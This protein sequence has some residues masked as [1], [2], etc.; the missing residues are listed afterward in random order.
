MY[1]V[2]QL[3]I[4]NQKDPFY[5]GKG[6]W[7][8][9]MYDHFEDAKRPRNKQ[10]NPLKCKVILSAHKLNQQVLCER[11]CEF[12]DE[13][14]ALNYEA[15]LISKYGRI[16]N[17]SGILTNIQ[18][19]GTQPP[20]QPTKTVFLFNNA[21]SLVKVLGSTFEA[22]DY[23]NVNVSVIQNCC[24]GRCKTCKGYILSYI[25]NKPSQEKIDK[26]FKRK[27]QL[28]NIFQYN[29][30]TLI[31]IHSSMREAAESIKS[32]SRKIS[33]AIREGC[34]HKGFYWK[35]N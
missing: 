24:A 33:R 22:A 14:T 30:D 2:Y 18:P 26:A 21:G 4:T 11:L 16:V 32:N 23:L 17:K 20:Q 15:T 34:R 5:I 12:T 25:E 10:D 35:V 7:N 13:D 31:A 29:N 19:G 27:V 9:R 8:S 1:Y 28:Q 6:S 3:R